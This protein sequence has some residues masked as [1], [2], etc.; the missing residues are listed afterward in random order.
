[1]SSVTKTN[2]SPPE[3]PAPRLVRLAF[4]VSVCVLAV[5]FVWPRLGY[6]RTNV[7]TCF[8]NAAGL[9]PGAGIRVAGVTV[10]VVRT[11]TA[12]ERDCVID[13]GMT[14]RTASESQIPADAVAEQVSDGKGGPVTLEIDTSRTSAG[15]VRENAL[16]K[17]REVETT[18]GD[19]V[20]R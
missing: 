18:G 17:S 8:H 15:P 16:L 20:V 11:V 14:V 7:H 19:Q 3:V 2:G 13:V 12:G 4:F 10:G 9:K 5:I 6:R 1:M